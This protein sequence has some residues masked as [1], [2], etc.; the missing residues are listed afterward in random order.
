MNKPIVS[1]FKLVKLI[2]YD[3]WQKCNNKGDNSSRKRT[4]AAATVTTTV[5]TTTK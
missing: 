5:T 2:V 1:V 3:A 4:T